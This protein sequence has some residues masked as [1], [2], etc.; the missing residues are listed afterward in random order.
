MRAKPQEDRIDRAAGLKLSIHGAFLDEASVIAAAKN[1][2]AHVAR[3]VKNAQG[4][5]SY[6]A[7][8]PCQFRGKPMLADIITGM[9]YEQHS[10]NCLSGRSFLTDAPGRA[11]KEYDSR[12][13]MTAWD[14]LPRKQ[15]RKAQPSTA[16]QG[17]P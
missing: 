1:R 4:E 2:A 7:F 12:A 13:K 14:R 15:R 3:M 10:G 17:Q 11:P 8:V 6:R 9:L 5:T 16:A